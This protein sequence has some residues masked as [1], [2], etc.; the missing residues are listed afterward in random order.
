MIKRYIF[1]I[2]L[3]AG[4][5]AVYAGCSLI[6]ETVLPEEKISM[7]FYDAPATG[8]IDYLSQLTDLPVSYDPAVENI[9]ITL[10]TPDP[11]TVTE[12]EKLIAAAFEVQDCIVTREKNAIT[13]RKSP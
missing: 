8:I 1:S 7:S 10:V 13:I 6:Q 11:V 5:V 12:A 4:I 2:L 9:T 3:C